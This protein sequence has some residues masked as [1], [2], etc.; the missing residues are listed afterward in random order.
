MLFIEQSD[1]GACWQMGPP[2]LVMERLIDVIP[3]LYFGIIRFSNV[4]STR[5]SRVGCNF[6]FSVERVYFRSVKARFK[7]DQATDPV[8]V[9]PICSKITRK[10]SI[11]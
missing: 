1:G 6:G 7:I 8:C 10:V 11:S 9:G 2:A 4:V 5:C 3:C